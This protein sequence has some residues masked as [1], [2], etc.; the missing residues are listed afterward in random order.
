MRDASA[1]VKRIENMV[2]GIPWQWIFDAPS[3]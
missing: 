1:L 3:G 2:P